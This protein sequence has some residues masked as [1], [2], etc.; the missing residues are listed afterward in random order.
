M[1]FF[2]SRFAIRISFTM[3]N[4]H[5]HY[6]IQTQATQANTAI[7]TYYNNNKLISS[8]ARTQWESTN[9]ECFK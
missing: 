6:T 1:Q 9:V 3:P 2:R 8:L 7:H 4:S 5:V